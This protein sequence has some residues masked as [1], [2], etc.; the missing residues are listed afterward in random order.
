MDFTE[1]KERILDIIE[2]SHRPFARVGEINEALIND[3]EA[4][5]IGRAIDSLERDYCI[6]KQNKKL[7]PARAFGY[8]KGKFRGNVKGFG[9]F[10]P[11]SE[12]DTARLGGDLFIP[13]HDTLDAVDGDE[14][15][16]FLTKD[17][18]DSKRGGEGKIVKITSRTLKHIIGT[19]YT[20][21]EYKNPRKI[22]YM[23]EADTN[24][25]PF[26][27]E[28]ENPKGLLDGD[29]VYCEIVKYPENYQPCYVRVLE[30][31][32]ES[33]GLGANYRA[34]L[35]EN[36]INE[37]FPDTVL[38]EAEA[39]SAR[40]ISPAGR[41]D[42]RGETILT[43]DSES[44]KDLDDAVSVQRVDDGFILGV[45]IA[46]VSD[47]VREGTE[48]DREA[49]KRGTSVYFTDKVVPMLPQVISNGCCSLTS[50]TDKYTLS[51]IMKI[52]NNGEI[53]ETTI[54]EGIINT[55]VRGVYSEINDII[56]KRDCGENSEFEEKYSSVSDML[57]DMLALY[58]IL[59][60]KGKRKGA[61]ELETTEA[62][63]VLRDGYPVD[64]VK[65]ERGVTERLI[66]QFMLAANEGVANW[67][68]W[69]DMPCVYR[70]HEEPPKD[71]MQTFATFAHNL[72]LDIK[73]LK[74]Q[75]GVRSSALEAVIDQ[76]RGTELQTTLSYV[77]L[78]SLA[79]AKYSP[80]SIPHFGLAIEKYCHFTSPI[81]R[82]P[83]LSVHRIIKKVLHGEMEGETYDYMV[84]FADRSARLSTE[85]EIKAVTAERAIDDLY[86]AL[87]M[88]D[89]VGEEF[90]GIIS[91]VTSF[92]FFVELENT[93][94]GL[95]PIRSLAGNFDYDES[96]MTLSYGYTTYR[97]GKKVR[98][99]ISKVDLKGGKIDMDLV[100]EEV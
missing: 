55:A 9:F 75:S 58:E 30:N 80:I 11:Q 81:R 57:P 62:K 3:A 8:F 94:E 25:F 37:K 10:M 64:I 53:I 66:E 79:K 73:G 83:D 76:V 48:L 47:Y 84:D 60:K 39:V 14:V 5:E 22:Y 78:R 12:E 63:I 85:N 42:F 21:Y 86:K 27:I 96:S 33:E 7:F 93:V 15:V 43:I 54:T 35:L 52:D 91:S 18:A 6:V 19:V 23:V 97:L 65:E 77:L 59:E 92:G 67:L 34:V 13:P 38:A 36:G 49:M 45:H 82:Y 44:A 41:A 28:I 89:K 16:A 74:S 69:Q 72:G 56:A 50:G 88:S 46:D 98:V 90:V 31:L 95:V 4:D 20:E 70:I 32:G 24:R 29:K 99:K 17:S 26:D 61:L 68:Y 100:S 40:E 87:Y 1:L 51:A 2:E 71:K